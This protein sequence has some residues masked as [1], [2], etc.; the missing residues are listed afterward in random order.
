MVLP[1]GVVT[2]LFTDV[3]GSTHMWEESPDLMMKA[4]EQHD[5][6]IDKAVAD[7]NGVSVKPRGEGDS[8]FV[9]FQSAHDA[10]TATAE[11]QRHLAAVDWVTPTQLRVR[12]SLHTG[13]ADLQLGD[14]Y[15][16]VVNRAARLRAIAHGGQT[17][18]SGATYELVQD[19]LPEGVTIRDMG[20]HGLKDQPQ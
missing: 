4:L 19:R 15:G 16:S 8:R 9:V 13:T 14:Y 11:M 5:H 6:A 2:F 7:N 10:V 18:M 20:A 12:A 1:D 17:I 3:E